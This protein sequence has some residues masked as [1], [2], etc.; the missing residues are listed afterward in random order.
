VPASDLKGLI[1]WLRAR[2]GNALSSTNGPGSAGYLI[3]TQFMRATG[4]TFQ[5][6]PYS[7]GSGASSVDLISG[8]TDLMFEQ[9][10]ITLPLVRSGMAKGYAVT[11]KTR[12]AIAPDIPTVD[13]AGL[14]GFYV[15]AWHGLWVPKGTPQ[16]IV[17]K[18][19]AAVVDALAEPNIRDRL[20]KLGQE[21]PPRAEQTPEALAAR[22]RAEI[23][24]WKPI[25]N[26]AQLQSH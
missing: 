26:A 6:V 3:G 25:I 2:G 20:V 11:A 24:I 21:I 9:V 8:H 12:M 14:P 17:S 22:Q 19:N 13:E 4:T 5:L 10:A 18:I 7:G 15:S 23:E 1:E 16:A